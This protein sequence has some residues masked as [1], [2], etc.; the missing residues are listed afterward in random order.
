VT[1]SLRIRILWLLLILALTGWLCLHLSFIRLEYPTR[2]WG[3]TGLLPLGGLLVWAVRQNQRQLHKLMQPHL[4]SRLNLKPSR[5]SQYLPFWL[6]M[7]VLSCLILALARPQG[8]PTF[9]NSPENG[10]NLLIALD[11]SDSSQATDLYPN[12]LEASK[13]AVREI[14]QHL[15]TDRVGLA[16][17]S[18]EA[19]SVSPFTHD[20]AALE[21]MLTDIDTTLLPSRGTNIPALTTYA[22]ERFSK[23]PQQGGVLLIFS[24]GENHQGD[25]TAAIEE[26]RSPRL[27]VFTIGAATPAGGQIPENKDDWGSS[28]FKQ[29]QG[30]TIIT[31]LN[32]KTLKAMAQAGNG[33]YANLGDTRRILSALDQARRELPLTETRDAKIS[34]PEERFQTYL[35]LALLLLLLSQHPTIIPI[36]YLTF[37]GNR[38][39][40]RLSFRLPERLKKILSVTLWIGLSLSLQAASFWPWL[41]FLKYQAGEKAYQAKNYTASLKAFEENARLSPDAAAPYYNQGS[42]LYQNQNYS[43]AAEAF[44]QSLQRAETPRQKAQSLYNLGNSYYRQGQQSKQPEQLWQQAVEAFEQA[45][46]LQPN[47]QQI[48][49]NHEFVKQQLKR[50]KSQAPN[51]QEKQKKNKQEKQEKSNKSNQNNN[52]TQKNQ[53]QK[54]PPQNQFS[55][56]EVEKFLQALEENERDN[57]ARKYFQR[58]PPPAT[59]LRPEDLMNKPLEELQKL[60]KAQKTEQKDW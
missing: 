50:L 42:A 16:V 26:L 15:I 29:Y 56:D 35:L 52:K 54:P 12:R 60:L 55:E 30:E 53:Q 47:D 38:A 17:F 31:R 13:Q 36:Q 22:R 43:Q 3:L 40:F 48:H 59:G 33:I 18:G 11:I 27:R 45:L 4:W 23:T 20:Y 2:L 41:P 57:R 21:T 34:S 44:R 58:T 1:T 37:S 24:D 6:Q 8:P 10:L 14:L 19:F 28:G 32:Q 9:N 7:L 39:G 25:A 51:K 49:E 5:H 46:K